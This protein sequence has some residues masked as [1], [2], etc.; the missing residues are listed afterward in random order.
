MRIITSK[1]VVPDAHIVRRGAS[2]SLGPWRIGRTRTA[3]VMPTTTSVF[4]CL[5]F[6]IGLCTAAYIIW[7]RQNWFD[8]LIAAVAATM[9]LL[10]FF[11]RREFA[12]VA[13]HERDARTN[14]KA[15]MLASNER[16]RLARE[17]DMAVLSDLRSEATRQLEQAYH[18]HTRLRLENEQL[19]AKLLP[20]SPEGRKREHGRFVSTKQKAPSLTI[21]SVVVPPERDDTNPAMSIARHAASKR[22]FVERAE[23]GAPSGAQPNE[24]SDSA[25]LVTIDGIPP[26][27]T[28]Y[29]G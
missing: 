6:A 21:G 3:G 13:D 29:P 12:F 14:L 28:V 7:W 23:S 27:E 22:T 11:V 25:L 19:K 15:Q 10:P 26:V 8:A 2:F 20:F 5:V 4:Y 9:I 16:L 18:D 17:H 1:R 24:E